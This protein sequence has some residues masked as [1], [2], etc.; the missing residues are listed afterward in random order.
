MQAPLTVTGDVSA[1]AEDGAAHEPPDTQADRT[2]TRSVQRRAGRRRQ[3]TQRAFRRRC[4]RRQT[5]APH[6]SPQTHRQTC[7][8]TRSAQRR[9]GRWRRPAQL[10][11]RRRCARRQTTATHTSR[12]RHMKTR[13]WTRSAQSHACRRHNTVDVSASEDDRDAYEPPDTQADA[14]AETVSVR[15]HRRA[16]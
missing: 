6:T 15:T 8:P 9:A 1:S 13:A 12:Q 5:K 14:H 3:P 2:P 4:A 16:A 7:T 10:V 11:Y